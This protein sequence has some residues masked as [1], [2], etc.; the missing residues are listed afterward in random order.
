MKSIVLG[1]LLSCPL[2][3]LACPQM[4]Q[5]TI[6][7]RSFLLLLECLVPIMP[8][9]G[10]HRY[11]VGAW[12]QLPIILTA[13]GIVFLMVRR[14]QIGRLSRVGLVAMTYVLATL[15]T[16]HILGPLCIRWTNYQC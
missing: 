11:G 3:A 5:H 2:M 7:V 16:N 4:P 10:E 8:I 14:S 12:V 9:I 6:G 15:A 1:W 13:C